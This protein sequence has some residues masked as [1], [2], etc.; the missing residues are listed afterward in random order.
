[1]IINIIKKLIYIYIFLK[2]NNADFSKEN[3]KN[4]V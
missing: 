3:E 1:M 4:Y 2:S